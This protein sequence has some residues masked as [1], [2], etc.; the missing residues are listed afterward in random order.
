LAIKVVKSNG[1]VEDFQPKKIVHTLRRAGASREAAR[2][3]V[4]KIEGVIHDGMTTNE[5]LKLVKAMIP[6]EESHV[7]MR[8]DLKGA[9]MRLGPAGYPFENFVAAILENY[10]YKTK[11]RSVINGRCVRHEIDI[12]AEKSNGDFLRI[13]VECKFHNQPGGTV[14]LK[15][16]MYTYARFMDLNE[17]G[18]LGKGDHFDEVWLASN[19]CGSADATKYAGCRGIKMFCWRYPRGAGLEKMIED[20]GLYPVTILRSVDKEVLEK[21]FSS[22][23]VLAKDFVE[24]DVDYLSRTGLK[25]SKIKKLMIEARQLLGQPDELG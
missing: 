8:Y 15:D 3:V 19:T 16:A 18:E 13:M 17:A 11:L 10:G 21:L 6:E 25:K 9:I 12:I 23:V 7:A 4:R 2:K 20:K 5:I 22:G 14:D 1:E 24:H